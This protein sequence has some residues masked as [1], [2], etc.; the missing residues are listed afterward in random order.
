VCPQITYLVSYRYSLHVDMVVHTCNPS[1][2]DTGAG[3]PWVWCQPGLCSE[4]LSQKT[5]E[6]SRERLHI[7]LLFPLILLLIVYRTFFEVNWRTH[8]FESSVHSVSRMLSLYSCE[9]ETSTLEWLALCY[10]VNCLTNCLYL[11]YCVLWI[12]SIVKQ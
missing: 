2:W 8:R 3:R 11:I 4:M 9:L 1:T 5:K 10:P 12:L 7:C 6:K